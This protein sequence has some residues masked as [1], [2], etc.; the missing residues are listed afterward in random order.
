MK[1]RCEDG[2]R[3]RGTGGNPKKVLKKIQKSLDTGKRTW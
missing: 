1:T 3:A 2:A